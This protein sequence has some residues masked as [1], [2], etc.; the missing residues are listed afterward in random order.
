M[1]HA[2]NILSEL[3]TDPHQED[4]DISAVTNF[5]TSVETAR[6]THQYD[7]LG[8]TIH[9]FDIFV[10]SHILFTTKSDGF[11]GALIDIGAQRS[12]IGAKQAKEY[13][14][15]FSYQRKILTMSR[16]RYQFGKTVFPALSSMLISIPT[17]TSDIR[18]IFDFVDCDFPFLVGLD[19]FTRN[20]LQPLICK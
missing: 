17:P 11:V 19:F 15:L 1:R 10:D 18:E 16:S 14:M 8:Q 5:V 7:E 3:L 13:T 12:V 2:P 9:N 4:R 6:I 20:H